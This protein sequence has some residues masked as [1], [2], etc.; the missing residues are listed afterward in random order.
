MKRFRPALKGFFGKLPARG[1][2]VRA[3]LPEEV[4][5]PLD[6]W[7]RKCI[8]ASRAALGAD[9]EQ[10]W[11]TAPIWRFL[12]PRGA[13]GAS[14]LLGVWLPSMDKT[15]R[16]YPFVLCAVADDVSVLAAGGNWLALAE[17]EGLAGVVADKP[18]A[19]IASALQAPVAPAPLPAPGWWTQGNKLVQPQ[20]LDIPALLP[21]ATHARVMLRDTQ[22]AEK[23]C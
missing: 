8:I 15:G 2:F 11:M 22:A 17:A 5:A 18:H 12:L 1:D 6:L 7:C 23:T 13:C 3:G 20:R 4:V 10:A 16:H 19:T 14:A 21:A 9:W